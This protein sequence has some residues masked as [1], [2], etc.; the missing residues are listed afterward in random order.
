MD[1]RPQVFVA[2][3]FADQ[4]ALRFTE[5]IAPAIQSVLV[6][7]VRLEPQVERRNA[8]IESGAVSLIPG[9]ETVAKLKAEFR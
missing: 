3:S 2:M 8:E 5:V 7:N 1:L 4:Y 9:P 6:D